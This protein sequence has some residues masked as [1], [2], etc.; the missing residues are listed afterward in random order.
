[1]SLFE[2]KLCPAFAL[3]DAG[4]D[5]F[6]DNGGAYA[7]N[8]LDSFTVVVETVGDDCFGAVLVGGYG[9]RRQG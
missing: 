7:A 3:G 6:F 4:V 2:P 1:M 9:L 8:G 5:V